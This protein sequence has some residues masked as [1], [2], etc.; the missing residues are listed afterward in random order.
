MTGLKLYELSDQVRLLL[1]RI[2]DSDPDDPATVEL[3][4]QLDQVEGS[5]ERKAEAL[6][7]R[8]RE[9]EADAEICNGEVARFSMRAQ[10]QVRQA[11]RWRGYLMTQ[12]RVAE[13]R[14]VQTARVT[15]SVRT[16]PPSV[17]VLEEAL[18]PGEFQ[19]SK[20]TI[21][22]DKVAI[23]THFETT[24]EVVPGTEIVRTER[25]EIR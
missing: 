15:V 17:K 13:L 4:L 7:F 18:V 14:R 5:F 22:V 3:L 19:R 2:E 11:E 21:S 16:N 10:I 6:A 1:D 23:K 12:M 25:L 24:G 20:T 8:I 9:I